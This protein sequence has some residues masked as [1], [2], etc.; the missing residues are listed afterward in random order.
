MA[1]RCKQVYEALAIEVEKLFTDHRKP[2]PFPNLSVFLWDG[3]SEDVPEMYRMIASY[4]FLKSGEKSGFLGHVRC[5][6][7]KL[8][9]LLH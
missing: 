1:G 8:L 2:N 4:Y 9:V 6:G 5:N 3:E 7:H